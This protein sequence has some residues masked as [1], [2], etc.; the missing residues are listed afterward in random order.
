MGKNG[1]KKTLG[2]QNT[3]RCKLMMNEKKNMLVFCG[4]T[5]VFWSGC[6]E[7]D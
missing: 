6:C 3:A 5:L 2:S 1:V 4:I 7:D